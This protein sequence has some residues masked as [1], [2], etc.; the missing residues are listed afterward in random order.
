MPFKVPKKFFGFIFFYFLLV[1]NL[2]FASDDKSGRYNF[3]YQE[4]KDFDESSLNKQ[5]NSSSLVIRIAVAL[6]SDDKLVHRIIPT[7]SAENNNIE[8]S[9]SEREKIYHDA[10]K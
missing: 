1:T 3:W 7:S 4:A 2:V 5:N 6:S 10:Q 8:H 9:F